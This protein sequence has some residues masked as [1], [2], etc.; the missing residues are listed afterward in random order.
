MRLAL[1]RSLDFKDEANLNS[2]TSDQTYKRDVFSLLFHQQITR[3]LVFTA[4]RRGHFAIGDVYVAG[5]DF[6]F[7]PCGYEEFPSTSECYVYPKQISTRRLS[8]VYE[9]VSGMVITRNMLYPD[10]FE[11]SGIRDYRPED[12][13]NHINWKASARGEGLMVNQFDA[14]TEAD[15]VLIVDLEDT[16]A[17]KHDE[18]TEE[19]IRIA[20]SFAATVLRQKLPLRIETNAIDV[21]TGGLWSEYYPAGGL[22]ISRMNQKFACVDTSIITEMPQ[23]L[24]KRI[25]E[26]QDYSRK[27]CVLISKNL[28]DP[29][30]ELLACLAPFAGKLLAVIPFSGTSPAPEVKIPGVQVIPW[31]VT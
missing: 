11:F 17:L 27:S 3:T 5:H 4:T 22:G 18:L 6:F 9:A 14:T 23:D 2:N 12:P 7:R 29:G 8:I 15:L 10:P 13:M 19:S 21:T 31:E 28:A 26:N 24:L 20:S 30:P 1:D 25:T 16:A